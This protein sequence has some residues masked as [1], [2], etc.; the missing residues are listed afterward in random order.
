MGSTEPAWLLAARRL[1]GT[2][3]AAGAANNGTILGWAKLLGLKVLGIAYNADSVP[4]CGLF[5]AHCLKAAGID[6]SNMKV[7]VRA[8]AWA[9]WGANLGA[10]VLAPGAILVFDREGGG[11]VAF[12]VGEDATHYHVL[13]G[14]Q[15]DKVSIM[16]LA[17][18][19]CI[20]RRW[21]RGVPVLG[22]PV[23]LSASGVPVSGNEA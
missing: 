12:Y 2:R 7:A 23:Y 15:G 14:N 22:R 8:K 11:H 21:P 16:R 17:K 18:G 9:T 13:G 6:L 20:A 5:V 1:L 4:W 3:E 10:S 19:R